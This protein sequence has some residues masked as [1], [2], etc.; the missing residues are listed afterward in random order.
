MPRTSTSCPRRSYRLSRCRAVCRKGSDRTSGHAGLHTTRI[1]DQNPGRVLL[2]NNG[3]VGIGPRTTPLMVS[4]RCRSSS[5]R[6]SRLSKLK[7]KKK[8]T[9]VTRAIAGISRT[10]M[11]L[12]DSTTAMI[13]ASARTSWAKTRMVMVTGIEKELQILRVQVYKI[14]TTV[15]V[16]ARWQEMSLAEVSQRILWRSLSSKLVT[17]SSNQMWSSTKRI[18]PRVWARLTKSKI[19]VTAS[20]QVVVREIVCLKRRLCTA[21]KTSRSWARA[22]KNKTALAC[23]TTWARFSKVSQPLP[24]TTN[25]MCWFN[26]KC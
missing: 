8:I 20:S 5:T 15:I 26:R 25:S 2:S 24:M 1:T 19:G 21:S 13:C 12:T 6:T 14:P 4:Y 18:H 16:T 10:S 9:T 11:K 23:S 17:L 22:W 7:A 3:R